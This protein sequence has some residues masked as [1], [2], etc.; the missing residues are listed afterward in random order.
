[1][2]LALYRKYRPSSFNQLV[3]QDVIKSTLSNAL[4]QNRIAN[5]YIFVGP[6]G[7]GKTSTARLMAKGLNCEAG[8][9]P[10]PCEQCDSC[11]S[12]AKGSSLDVIEVDAAS[13]TGIDNIRDLILS[14]KIPPIKARYKVFI[15]DEVHMLSNA[16]FN[17]LL[18]TLE[19]PSPRTIFILATTEVHKVLPTILS[20]CQRYQFENIDEQVMLTHLESI[21]A[22]ENI[23]Y[24]KKALQVITAKAN[25]GLRDALTLLEQASVFGDNNIDIFVVAN[26]FGSYDDELMLKISDAIV[27][28]DGHILDLKKDLYL[29]YSDPHRI[30]VLL[31]EHVKNLAVISI[32]KDI[33]GFLTIFSKQDEYKKQAL[34][35]ESAQWFTLLDYLTKEEYRIRYVDNPNLFLELILLNLI[36]YEQM[37]AAAAPVATQV[38]NQKS[39]ATAAIPAAKAAPALIK[40]DVPKFDDVKAAV[41]ANTPAVQA[42]ASLTGGKWENF[43]QILEKN[44]R[45]AYLMFNK[46]AVCDQFDEENGI[47]HLIFREIATMTGF[48]KSSAKQKV[49]DLL[50]ITYNKDFNI[51]SD[52]GGAKYETTPAPV[53]TAQPTSSATPPQAAGTAPPQPAA[54]AAPAPQG[55]DDSLTG[56][57]MDFF[58]GAKKVINDKDIITGDR[59]NE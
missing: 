9:N 3:G 6:R 16:A 59:E 25:G 10:N 2:A 4:L 36:R 8:V 45:A 23:T 37:Q 12:I 55:A 15:I 46:N 44:Q 28:K 18:K 58:P 51:T 42:G 17:A 27:N 52:V 56:A 47:V 53:K 20:R 11:L 7:T 54:T 32:N 19:E 30:V 22:Q 38:T 40:A 57:I 39:T 41:Q 50:K 5:S 35:L 29:K 33:P 34:S 13:H 43:A 1:M 49:L 31:L 14:S 26:M 21:C 48:E 24:D